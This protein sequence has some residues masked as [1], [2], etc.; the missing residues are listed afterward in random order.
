MK[1]RHRLRRLF[2]CLAVASWALSAPAAE[3]IVDLTITS[4][5]VPVTGNNP[6]VFTFTGLPTTALGGI[7]VTLFGTAD[8]DGFGQDLS[9]TLSFQIDGIAFGPIGPF[10]ARDFSH[11]QS[12]FGVLDPLITDG[13]LVV[14]VSLGAGVDAPLPGDSLSVRLNY[15]GEIADD[16]QIPAPGSL[17]LAMLGAAGLAAT[18][19]RGGSRPL[20]WRP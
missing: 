3:V 18:R 12:T 11:T 2:A 10:D 19:R 8:V 7:D 6:F 4:P 9:E 14:T 20:R 16:V 17:A 13:T 1:F 5:T 15:A